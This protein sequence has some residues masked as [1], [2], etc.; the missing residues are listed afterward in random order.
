MCVYVYVYVCMYTY[1]GFKVEGQGDMVS[2]LIRGITR[3]STGVIGATNLL[4]RLWGN[5]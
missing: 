5:Y 1:I 2:G 4:C 3:V